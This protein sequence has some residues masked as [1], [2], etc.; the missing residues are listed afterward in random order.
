MQ[1]TA[2]RLIFS[3]SLARFDYYVWNNGRVTALKTLFNRCVCV[4]MLLMFFFRHK[5]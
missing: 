5:I 2:T 1:L 3:S 4:C